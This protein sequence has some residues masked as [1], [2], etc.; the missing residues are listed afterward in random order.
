MNIFQDIATA[1]L[2]LVAFMALM[3][4]PQRRR[5]CGVNDLSRWKRLR[6]RGLRGARYDESHGR[7]RISK[8]SIMALEAGAKKG[9]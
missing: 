2:A 9:T 6:G 3:M 5:G 1:A 7:N 4:V 8:D